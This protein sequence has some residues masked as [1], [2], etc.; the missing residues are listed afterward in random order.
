[1]SKFHLIENAK[2]MRRNGT[3]LSEICSTLSISKSTASIWC[4]DIQLTK[5]QLEHIAHT[6]HLKTMKGRMLGTQANKDKKIHAV[7]KAR[8]KAEHTIKPLTKYEK[9]IT[10]LMLYWAEGSKGDRSSFQ[11]VNS[12]PVMV[13]LVFDIIRDYF[14]IKKID[15]VCTIQINE[16]H[17]PRIHTVLDFWQNL[18][19]LPSEQFTKV[20]YIK[21]A[22]KK[23]YTN[24]DS[25]FGVCRLLVR[26]STSLKYQVVAM[27]QRL[28]E[29]NMPM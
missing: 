18:L 10:F 21:T 3:T 20:V 25:Y 24:H 12:D 27:I 6:H 28:K 16:S 26:R 17:R 22:S 2:R 11:F 7:E 9:L 13:R 29:M 5:K 8:L 14:E 19:E 4:K 15:I 23:V 1:M